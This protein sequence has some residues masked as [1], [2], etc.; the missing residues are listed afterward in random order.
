MLTAYGV[1]RGVYF[2]CREPPA[3][4]TAVEATAVTIQKG[5]AAMLS[6]SPGKNALFFSFEQDEGDHGVWVCQKTM[7][8][9]LR[10]PVLNTLQC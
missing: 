5:T 3:I 7:I 1:E 10:H 2:D 9:S 8:G 6:F 4:M